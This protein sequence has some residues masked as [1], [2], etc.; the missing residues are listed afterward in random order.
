MAELPQ[1]TGC[2]PRI[3]FAAHG[4]QVLLSDL[5][6]SQRKRRLPSGAKVSM[7][8]AWRRTEP[9]NPLVLACTPEDAWQWSQRKRLHEAAG[10]SHLLTH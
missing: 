6:R 10:I 4:G 8:G 2:R 5:A 1:G 3:A 7:K 9:P